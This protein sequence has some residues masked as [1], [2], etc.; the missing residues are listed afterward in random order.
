MGQHF[1][2]CDT[3]EMISWMLAVP[4]LKQQNARTKNTSIQDTH[5][6]RGTLKECVFTLQ[7]SLFHSD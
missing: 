3:N 2:L 6:D 1:V 7:C 5:L 4:S